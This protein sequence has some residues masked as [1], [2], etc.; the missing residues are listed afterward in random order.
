MSV[1]GSSND[2]DK[3]N[4]LHVPNMYP[5]KQKMIEQ[6]TNRKQNEK[7]KELLESLTL[8]NQS[9]MN[10]TVIK[11]DDEWED[12]RED[13]TENGQ[14]PKEHKAKKAF[15]K[16]F[17]KILEMADIIVEVLDA[18]DPVSCR[19]REAEKLISGMKGEKKLI[20]V[21]NKID[22]V[23]LPIVYAWKKEL[24]KEYAVVLFKANTQRQG[25]NYGENRLY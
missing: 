17:N 3:T 2:L 11:Q 10:L 20:L 1:S 9:K 8:K 4:Q 16:E 6:L 15:M 23:P 21:L 13:D 24:E 22:L 14:T 25:V 19:C 7:N 18:R 12:V 5:L